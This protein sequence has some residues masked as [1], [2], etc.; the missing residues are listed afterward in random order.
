ME[1]SLCEC[2]GFSSL[3]QARSS[4]YERALFDRSGL[5]M[6][7][8]STS[9]AWMK[10]TWSRNQCGVLQKCRRRRD[11]VWTRSRPFVPAIIFSHVNTPNAQKR[12]GRTTEALMKRAWATSSR[13]RSTSPTMARR[14]CLV[15]LLKTLGSVHL[16]AEA[17]SLCS[18]V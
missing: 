16:E 6:V 14:R 17:G 9:Y 1:F 4:S 3:W 10:Q 15:R 2:L 13:T 11:N 7:A 5:G 18:S 12:P 8:T